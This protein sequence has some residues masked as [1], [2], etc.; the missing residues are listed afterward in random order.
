MQLLRINATP[1]ALR[2]E[3]EIDLAAADQLAEALRASIASGTTS[4][5]LSDVTFID[6]S[7]LHVLVSA[8][9]AL[10]GQGPLVLLRPSKSVKRLLNI[11]LPGGIPTLAVRDE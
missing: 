9:V 7:G 4:V 10:D 1:E 6:S 5:D 3:G 2:L 11:A 8:A